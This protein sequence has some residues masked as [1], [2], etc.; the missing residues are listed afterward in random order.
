MDLKHHF[1]M[2]FGNATFPHNVCF[3]CIISF[4]VISFIVAFLAQEA[5]SAR[6]DSDCPLGRLSLRPSTTS[7][8]VDGTMTRGG[9]RG[10]RA[11]GKRAVWNDRL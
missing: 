3:V 11:L 9:S 7:C 6:A 1:E 4:I 8:P 10:K 2:C 5:P